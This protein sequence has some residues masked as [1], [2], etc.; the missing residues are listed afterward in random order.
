LASDR[1]Q[2]IDEIKRQSS[3]YRSRRRLVRTPPPGLGSSQSWRWY[4]SDVSVIRCGEVWIALKRR[5]WLRSCVLCLVHV[6]CRVATVDAGHGQS[7]VPLRWLSAVELK[8]QLERG[9]R[10]P[11]HLVDLRQTAAFRESHLPG[12]RS[13]PLQELGA[14]AREIPRGQIVLYCD[15]PAREVENAYNLLWSLGWDDV[16]ALADGYQGWLQHGYPVAR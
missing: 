2:K 9:S 3:A 15:C 12:S 8:M 16:R 10:A 1:D 7:P 4:R 11:I 13:I 14:R 5:A 6:V